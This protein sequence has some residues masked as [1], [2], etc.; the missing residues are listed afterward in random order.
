MARV[1]LDCPALCG[2][3]TDAEGRRGFARWRPSVGG[4][5]PLKGPPEVCM[6]ADVEEEPNR[7]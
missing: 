2:G 7:Q 5:L 3:A 6:I 4:T 1:G